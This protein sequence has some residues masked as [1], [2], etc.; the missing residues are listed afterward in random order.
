MTLFLNI[1]QEKKSMRK[2]VRELDVGT[3]LEKG[4][5]HYYIWS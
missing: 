1:C 3:F 4:L 2:S 5:P